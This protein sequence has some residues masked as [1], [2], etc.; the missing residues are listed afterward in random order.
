MLAGSKGRLCAMLMLGMLASCSGSDGVTRAPDSGENGADGGTSVTGPD[1]APTATAGLDADVSDAAP[2]V[3]SPTEA[4]TTAPP[5]PD[6]APPAATDA[7]VVPPQLD[8]APTT[9]PVDDTSAPPVV[10]DSGTTPVGPGPTDDPTVTPTSDAATDEPPPEPVDAGPAEQDAGPLPEPPMSCA[11]C[12]IGDTCFIEGDVN[13]SNSCVYCNVATS[14][15]QWSPRPNGTRCSDGLFCN[16]ADS[17]H[18]GTC[19]THVGRTCDD[20][21]DCNGV[22]S[23]SEEANRCQRGPAECQQG[24]FCDAETDSCV[25]TCSGCLIDDTCYANGEGTAQDLC[26]VC[27]VATSTSDWSSHQGEVCGGGGEQQQCVHCGCP[28]GLAGPNC[29][30]CVVFVDLDKSDANE[31]TS[32]EQAVASVQVGIE[33]AAGYAESQDLEEC[34][35]WVRTGIYHPTLEEEDPRDASFR[36]RSRVALYGGFAGGEMALGD[37][38]VLSNSTVLSGD[39]A[40]DDGSEGGEGGSEETFDD[41][42][43]HVVIGASNALIDG[44]TIMG[45][46]ADGGIESSTGVGGGVYLDGTSPTIRNCRITGNLASAGGGLFAFQSGALISDSMFV[47]NA[48]FDADFLNGAGGG[49]Y[50]EEGALEFTGVLFVNNFTAGYGAGLYADDFVSVRNSRFQE[51]FAL[52]FEFS[53]YGGAAFVTNSALFS[54]TVFDAN[55]ATYGGAVATISADAGF[56]NCTFQDN[57]AELGGAAY[58]ATERENDGAPEYLHS[59]FVGNQAETGSVLFVEGGDSATELRNCIVWNNGATPID[60][61]ADDVS[62]SY[63]LITGDWPG[64]G[65][66]DCDPLFMD[67]AV[68]DFRL[69]PGSPAIDASNPVASI[70]VYDVDGD[71]DQSE[72]LPLDQIRSSAHLRRRC[73]P[74]S[75]RRHGRS[76]SHEQPS[77]E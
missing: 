4:G 21:I 65:N 26:L 69:K 67:E 6:A 7:S 23:C 45:G 47:G 19:S 24:E 22:E 70:D 34:Q 72:T 1:A 35:V 68:G 51:N 42:S 53:T 76:R 39:L 55:G 52:E 10:E 38:N 31:G 8:A 33:L 54:A 9:A 77:S 71:G 20:G 32:W 2:S 56:M 36:L 41:N 12:T 13:P 57:E 5:V 73:G 50:S 58:H 11:G 44:F 29:D 59:T 3:T 25:E 17:C 48:A 49:A 66:F 63:T 64:P 14:T 40:D 37:R 30:Q 62:V 46:I 74:S 16:G 75:D 28:E 27:D 43:Y 18:N 60:G 61:N 15:T